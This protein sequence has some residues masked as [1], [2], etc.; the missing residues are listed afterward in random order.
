MYFAPASPAS[1]NEGSADGHGDVF[2]AGELL[3]NDVELGRRDRFDLRDF[4]HRM[5]VERGELRL[6]DRF[7]AHGTGLRLRWVFRAGDPRARLFAVV[8]PVD[9]VADRITDVVVGS[10]APVQSVVPSPH[11]HDR[12]RARCAG[13]TGV[14]V[15]E[16]RRQRE[17]GAPMYLAISSPITGRVGSPSAIRAASGSGDR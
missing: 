15:I 16:G 3:A 5:F 4:G 7:A 11:L 13:P 2:P 12:E 14:R 10:G 9:L 8:R 6:V 17:R 1:A